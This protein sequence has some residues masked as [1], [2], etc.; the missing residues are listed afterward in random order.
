MGDFNIPNIHWEDFSCSHT[1][2]SLVNE[3][4]CAIQDNY[5]IQHVSEFTRH[6]PGQR[7]SLLDLVFALNPNSIDCVQHCTPLGSSDHDCL[8]FKFK[9]Y[10]THSDC[11]E[12]PVKLNF[13]KGNV[14]S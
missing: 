13:R 8:I 10:T 3:F 6:S 5:L 12:G 2:S 4:L 11:K 9:C 1:G 14:R 7:S